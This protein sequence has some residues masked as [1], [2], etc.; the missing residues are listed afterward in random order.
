MED[1]HFAAKGRIRVRTLVA[2][3][4]LIVSTPS[5]AVCTVNNCRGRAD[6]VV[7]SVYPHQ[8]GNIYLEAPQDRSALHCTLK[9]GLLMTLKP[10]NPTYREMYATVLTAL[11]TGSEFQVRV[12][13]QSPDCEVLYVRMW[14]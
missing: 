7:V 2:L 6:E 4:A 1:R 5:A 3:V 11:S 14:N 9:D 8:N 10:A 13:E 12:A